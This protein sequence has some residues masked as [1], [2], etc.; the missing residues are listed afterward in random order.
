[1]GY[2]SAII[3]K[4]M[5]RLGRD[6]LQVGYYTDTF[7]PDH[8]IRFIAI[9]D[10][11]D[12]DD[13]ENELA[14]F[15]NVMNEMYARDIS[16]KVRS[17]HRLRGNAGE[18]LS[19]PP[20]GYM[21]SPENKKQWIIEPYAA[22]VVKD[23]FQMCIEGKGNDSIARTL[24][25]RGI[26]NCTAYWR[27]RGIGRGGK[28]TQPNPCKWKCSTIAKILSR[29]EY[30]GDIVNF[31]TY[32]KSFKNKARIDNPEENWVIFKDRHEPIIDRETF[33][34][35]QKLTSNTKRRAPKPE[36]A[37]K[38]MFSELLYCADCGSKLWYHTNPVNKDMPIPTTY[39]KTGTLSAAPP[40]GDVPVGSPTPQIPVST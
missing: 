40:G 5:S 30:C 12:S 20:Y 6:Y 3:V 26:L 35:V 7:F 28:K 14:P 24:Q 11:V 10:C 36:N 2:V 32:S 31:K 25:D 27:E 33:E 38:S 23:I 19:Q 8:N 15:R 21:K 9:N 13:G 22:S 16:R 37:D 29:R 34:L 18:P 1:M 39:W 4:D 17:S